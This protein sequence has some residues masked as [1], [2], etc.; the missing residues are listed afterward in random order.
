MAKI[1]ER[2]GHNSPVGLANLPKKNK[3]D[4]MVEKK[5]LCSTWVSI[6]FSLCVFLYI[7]KL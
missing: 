1:F 5:N 4:H 3:I 6:S 7:L 2:T